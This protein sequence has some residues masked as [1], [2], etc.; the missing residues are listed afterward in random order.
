MTSNLETS[1]ISSNPA[2]ATSSFQEV[3]PRLPLIHW[4]TFRNGSDNRNLNS[5]T[6]PPS[7]C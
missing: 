4:N 7:V 1:S 5:L 6:L 2:K 3:L